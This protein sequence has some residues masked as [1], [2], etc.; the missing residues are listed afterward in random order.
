MTNEAKISA[1][2]R[3]LFAR[4]ARLEAQLRE[5]DAELAKARGEYRDETRVFVNDMVRFRNIVHQIKVAA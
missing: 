5:I 2:A 4:R 1:H 3:K